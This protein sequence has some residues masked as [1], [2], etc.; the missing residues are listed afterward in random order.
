LLPEEGAITAIVDTML[1]MELSEAIQQYG[2]S[3][4]ANIAHM[5]QSGFVEQEHTGHVKFHPAPNVSLGFQ[6]DEK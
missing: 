3:A 1:R 5:G 4:L 6:T 2:C